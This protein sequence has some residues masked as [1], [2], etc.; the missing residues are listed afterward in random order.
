MIR[1]PPRSTRTDTLLPDTTLFRAVTVQP[2]LLGLLAFGDTLKAEA[3]P[4]IARLHALGIRT[5][6]LT[7]DNRGSATTVARQLDIDIVH[8]QVLHEDKA[9]IVAQIR[10][11]DDQRHDRVAKDGDGIND[12][13]ALAAAHVDIAMY[14]DRHVALH[15]D[16]ITQ[17]R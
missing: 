7:G 9:A 2:Q 15:A 3:G 12:A 10:A 1:R 13:P 14:T 16:G 5:A 6:M 8:S 17:M 4:A 11:Q